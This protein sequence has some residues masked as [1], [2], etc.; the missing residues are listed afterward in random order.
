MRKKLYRNTDEALV[1]GVLAGLADYYQQDVVLFRFAFVALL[2]LTGLMP[3]VLFYII[4]TLIIPVRPQI[5]PVD[6]ADY[7]IYS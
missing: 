3:G 4:A 5:E 6:Q 7:T 2:F 1:S